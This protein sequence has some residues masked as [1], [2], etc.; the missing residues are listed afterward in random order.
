[1]LVTPNGSKS[2]SINIKTT[3]TI[4]DKNT[5]YII[6]VISCAIPNNKSNNSDIK[7]KLFCFNGSNLGQFI[8]KKASSKDSEWYKTVQKISS[9][10]VFNYRF[11]FSSM[12]IDGLDAK[13]YVAV[14]VY[15]DMSD[16]DK[17]YSMFCK[18]IEFAFVSGVNKNK[19]DKGYILDN[20]EDVRYE[21]V[22]KI[23]DVTSKGGHKIEVSVMDKLTNQVLK[24]FALKEG[25]GKLNTFQTLL[26]EQLE[27]SAEEFGDKL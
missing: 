2:G 26:M 7:S 23:T 10:P 16:I 9:V 15:Q 17:S 19:K 12:T 20:K 3:Y 8:F 22:L 4:K 1:M 27:K 13:E 11:D 14:N 6:A 25:D 5:G 24:E 21:I 18:K